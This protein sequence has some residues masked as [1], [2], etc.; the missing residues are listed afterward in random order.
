MLAGELGGSSFKVCPENAV[1]NDEGNVTG[2]ESGYYQE[3]QTCKQEIACDSAQEFI[4]T[5]CE[6]DCGEEVKQGT[7]N[8]KTGEWENYTVTQA[9]P[10]K[11]PLTKA[12]SALG[13]GWSSGTAQGSTQCSGGSW[14]EPTWD[15]EPCQKECTG[16][17]PKAS[18]TC[19]E[20][21][22]TSNQY[23]GTVTQNVACDYTTGEW[24]VSNVVANCEGRAYSQGN[25]QT[26]DRYN[27]TSNQYCGT[28]RLDNISCDNASAKWTYLWK[29][30]CYSKGY[31]ESVSADDFCGDNYTKSG[32]ML[33]QS[34]TCN[35][36]NQWSSYTIDY[37]MCGCDKR[38]KSTA[39]SNKV[40]CK[41]GY[42]NPNAYAISTTQVCNGNSWQ[43]TSYDYSA[44]GS[45]V[46][47]SGGFWAY[48]Y[49]S[50]GY[51]V[52]TCTDWDDY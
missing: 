28:K 24:K 37:S 7:C 51:I 46:S 36:G 47:C 40:R 12:C 16:T 30:T 6:E 8:V 9:C 25:T 45:K 38:Q 1:C 27:G 41:C 48:S 32:E 29:G 19:D 3:E 2:C 49:T 23:C 35:G 34:R 4:R 33:T 14:A 5:S 44:C 50:D 10:T 11:P 18:Q 22:G 26:C 39:T 43:W 20:Y 42:Q 52:C 21:Y 17:A 13:K 31:K 15:E